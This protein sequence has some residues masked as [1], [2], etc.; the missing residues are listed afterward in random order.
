MRFL[1]EDMNKWTLELCTFHL[2]PLGYG[3]IPSTL[4]ESCLQKRFYEV[5]R[6]HRGYRSGHLVGLSPEICY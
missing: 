2:G 5:R 3:L 6:Y 4:I 1:F